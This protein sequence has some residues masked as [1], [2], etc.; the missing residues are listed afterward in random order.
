MGF[1]KESLDDSKV[2]INS[3]DFVLDLLVLVGKQFDSDGLKLGDLGVEPHGGIVDDFIDGL[4]GG[5]ESFLLFGEAFFIGAD[6]LG[7]GVVSEAS[8]GFNKALNLSADSL[9]L[10]GKGGHFFA[11]ALEQF[12]E[13]LRGLA[14]VDGLE[15]PAEAPDH[16]GIGAM[17]DESA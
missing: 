2:S 11:G 16:E 4:E 12:E 7:V 6:L 5:N 8:E 17:L 14:S 1:S 9:I 3:L 13:L 15:H 10:L